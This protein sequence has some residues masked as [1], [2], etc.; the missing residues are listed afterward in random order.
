MSDAISADDTNNQH[1]LQAT[2]GTAALQCIHE[3]AI[4]RSKLPL[5]PPQHPHP[6]LQFIP[7]SPMAA[8]G[9]L[10]PR[11]SSSACFPRPSRI[12][13]LFCHCSVCGRTH[14]HL[15][16]VNSP[17]CPTCGHA[18]PNFIHMNNHNY[19]VC[20]G[21]SYTFIEAAWICWSC[22][23]A[24]PVRRISGY[25]YMKSCCENCGF[26]VDSSWRLA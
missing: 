8:H 17:G 6:P 5:L 2:G 4:C 18:S 21:C 9:S 14:R 7:P 20:S 26:P 23:H 11:P 13:H 3:S 1:D 16:G 25:K 10:G 12:I 24:C 15:G 22:N 19:N